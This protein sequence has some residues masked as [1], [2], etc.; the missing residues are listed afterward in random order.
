MKLRRKAKKN[1]KRYVRLSKKAMYA[2]YPGY[3][4]D[5]AKH[6]E[7]AVVQALTKNAKRRDRATADYLNWD[8]DFGALFPSVTN[9]QDYSSIKRSIREK[10]YDE[11]KNTSRWDQ[12]IVCQELQDFKSWRVTFKNYYDD[13]LANIQT[14]GKFDTIDEATNNS[15]EDLICEDVEEV[16]DV[17]QEV[18]PFNISTSS[19]I[20]LSF[21]V[22]HIDTL[23]SKIPEIKAAVSRILS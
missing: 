8:V 13:A 2:K 16:V 9:T 10:F 3:F 23:T 7:T 11:A 4:G 14:N 6:Y 19:N 5:F 21:N 15:L 20:T 18:V 12:W 22:S 1:T 17:Q